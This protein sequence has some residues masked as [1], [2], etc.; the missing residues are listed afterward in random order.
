MASPG[1]V[2]L[3]GAGLKEAK[4]NNWNVVEINIADAGIYAGLNVS[5]LTLMLN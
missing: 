4:A 2:H 5:N 1:K 3:G